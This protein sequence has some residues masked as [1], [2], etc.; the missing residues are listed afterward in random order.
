MKIALA[1]N[2]KDKTKLSRQTL[3]PLLDGARKNQF[4]LFINDGSVTSEGEEF[5]SQAGYPTAVVTH[6]VRGGPDAAIVFALTQL[7]QHKENYDVVGLVENDVLLADGW[8]ERTVELFSRGEADGL[9][10]GAISARCYEDRILVQRSGYALVHNLGAGLI[11]LTREAAQLV[12]ENFRTG[13]WHDNRA[14]FCQLSGL[15]I[16]RWGAFRA[17]EQ[18]VG[19]D[20]H[21]ETVLAR[22]GLAAL[23]LTPSPCTMIGQVPP[24]A[25]QGL[26]LVEQE[27]D[28]L[29]NDDAFDHFVERSALVRSG[30]YRIE[31][32]RF[33]KYTQGVYTY[34]PHQIEAIGGDY[35]G[36]WHLGWAQGFGP[37][38][39]RAATDQHDIP[40][41]CQLTV[42]VFGPCSVLISGGKNGGRF[43]LVDETSGFTV[44]P[45]MPP[46]GDNT[47]VLQVVV[48]GGVVSRNI[49]LTALTPGVIFYGLQTQEP[50]PIMMSVK[51]DHSKLPPV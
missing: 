43:D 36:D 5:A 33:E 24:L 42:P 32:P 22:H 25:E 38:P 37:F 2:C 40:E 11:F 1:F 41:Q 8:F 47:Q 13:W 35:R 10:V 49:R 31:M 28:G 50:Q 46:E 39:Y 19:S 9:R 27:I 23:A 4:H 16:G 26:K 17:N 7:L 30:D 15:D 51:F 6:N 34:Y 3:L 45:E 48:P 21:F 29:R 44:S 14:V 12:L 20:W 18:Q